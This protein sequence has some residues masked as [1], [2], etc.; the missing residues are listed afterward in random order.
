MENPSQTGQYGVVIVGGGPAGLFAAVYAAAVYAVGDGAGVLLL[1]RMPGPGRKLLASGGGQ[2]NLTHVGS[3][4]ELLRHYRSSGPRE[5]ASRFL[6]PALYALP[7][8]EL[9][10]WFGRRGI[11]FVTEENGK[12]FPESRR[13]S[14]LLDALVA[15]ARALG[16]ETR[17]RTRVTSAER[18]PDGFIIHTE[19]EEGGPSQS[20]EARSLVLA[21]GGASYPSTGSSGDGY[22][23]AAALGHTVV[24]PRP[25]L[26]P[27][28]ARGCALSAL[29]GLS[30]K[31][32]G[33]E[34]RRG[35]KK[36]FS[37]R[38]ELLITHKGLSGPLILDSS[39]DMA[40]GDVLLVRFAPLEREEF[41][42]ALTDYAAR[43]PSKPVRGA[44]CELGLTRG[45]AE[46]FLGL[47]SGAD[48]SSPA[49][50]TGAAL[51]RETRR[52]L[53]ECAC[54]YPVTV[55][56]LGG[57]DEAMA[58]AGG[59]ALAQVAPKTMESRLV[60][61][62]FFAGELLDYAGDT[63]GYNIH[64]AFATGALA[65]SC[66]AKAAGAIGE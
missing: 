34:L 31:D 22:A 8:D 46:L 63:G 50:L 43:H 48:A 15:E 36:L 58:T 25:A 57:M 27:V 9:L 30:F 38:G 16:V 11:S 55:S 44:L 66:A 54:A 20:F 53:A 2:C 3:P 28:F 19:G 33:I 26:A 10:A 41:E 1:E 47:A 49:G 29:S 37:R 12:V 5:E 51:R 18:G 32:A 62:L 39:G 40:P 64:A 13:A 60:P 21:S 61:S 42:D 7:P 45:M 59:V 4:Q 56:A 65:G 23:L 6:R 35:G 24:P 52:S 14:R 17:I